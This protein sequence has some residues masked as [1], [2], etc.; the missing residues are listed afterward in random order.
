MT[1][2]AALLVAPIVLVAACRSGEHKHEQWTCPMHPQ[3]VSD[4]PGDC[5]ICGM[6]LVVKKAAATESRRIL[7]YRNPMNPAD[8]SPTPKKDEMGMDYV[9]VY[10]DQASAP[11]GTVTIDAERQRMIGLKTVEV[12]LAPLSGG[13][14]TTGRI[15]VDER[16]VQKVT[17]RFEGYIEKLYADFTGKLVRKGDP[18]LSVYSPDL[19]ATQEE[20]L[21]AAKSGAILAQSGLPDAARAAR[22]RLR[23]FGISDGEIER[24][25]KRG[26][27]ERALTLHAPGSGFITTKSAVAGARVAPN[28]P[29]F[30]IVDLSRVWVVADVYEHEL[31][32]LQLGRTATLTL[33]Y[34]PNRKWQGKV[35]YILPT[36]DEKSRTVKVRIELANPKNELKPEMFGD[37]VIDTAPRRGL[38][39]P[40]D[41]V[42]TTGARKL[43]FVAVGEGRLEP[44]TVETGLHVDGQYELTSGVKAGDKV[45]AGASFLVDSEAQLRSATG[46]MGGDGGQ[47]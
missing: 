18:L 16:R 2:Y 9:A 39:V 27:A 34:W 20:Y 12:R 40:E 13:I 41:A 8:T 6:K 11:P 32:R 4:K 3:Y 14:R 43:V 46:G 21:L 22:D 7:F 44:R 30:E 42:I 17:A 10:A 38:V 1:R 24:L 29:L 31:P 25:E 33:A 36:V 5:P 35:S 45:A 23:L 28:E 15:T 37:V 47:P 26:T 19:L